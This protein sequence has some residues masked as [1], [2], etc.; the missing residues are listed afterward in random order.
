MTKNWLFLFMVLLHNSDTS[1]VKENIG[2]H[3]A[4]LKLQ[5]RSGIATLPNWNE[6]YIVS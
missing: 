5:Q 3:K 6:R 1:G 4:K 2:D